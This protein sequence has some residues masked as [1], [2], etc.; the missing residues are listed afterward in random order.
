MN[1]NKKIDKSAKVL[2]SVFRENN[3]DQLGSEVLA[4]LS[5]ISRKSQKF[6]QFLSTKRIELNTKKE[7]LSNIFSDILNQ[8]QLSLIYCLLDNIDF[9]YL[10]LIDKKYQKLM[11]DSKGHVNVKTITAF[12]LSDSELSDLESSIR[13]KTNSAISIDNITDKSILGGIKLKVGNTLI[14]ASLSTKLE[15][16]KQSMINK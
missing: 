5:K 15:K 8:S 7:I 16:L 13:L 11:Q 1:Q 10:D 12:Q 6:K 3:V 2:F 9:N 4:T 14:D